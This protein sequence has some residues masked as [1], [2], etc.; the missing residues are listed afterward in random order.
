MLLSRALFSAS[1][2]SPSM[3]GRRASLAS[4]CCRVYLAGFETSTVRRVMTK[5]TESCASLE[6]FS[7]EAQDSVR[8]V[9]TRRTVEVSK[10]A[11]YTRQ[12]MLAKLARLPDMDGEIDEAENKALDNSIYATLAP[13][14]LPA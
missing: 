10:P 6:K 1:S 12:Q 5:R 7:K 2:I 8:F 13:D 14:D 4:I 9:I 11:K 3:S